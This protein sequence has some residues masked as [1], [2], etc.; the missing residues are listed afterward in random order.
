MAERNPDVTAPGTSIES[1]RVPG[2]FIDQEHPEGYVDEQLFKGSG[3]SQAAAVVAGGVALLL[4][5]R[6]DLTPD[7]I[8]SLLM[9]KG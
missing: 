9:S 5:A 8:K 4:D 2:S 6:P 3:S 7:E 1:L